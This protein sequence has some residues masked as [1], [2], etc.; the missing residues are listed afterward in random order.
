MRNPPNY[1]PRN[2][3]RVEQ[4]LEREDGVGLRR[5]S[6]ASVVP[7]RHGKGEGS[8][9]RVRTETTVFVELAGA[10]DMFYRLAVEFSS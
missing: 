4:V 10:E 1:R 2:T 3:A 7:V 9:G 5:A 6:I 8:A